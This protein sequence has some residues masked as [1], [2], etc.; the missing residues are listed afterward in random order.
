M[1]VLI[2]TSSFPR[3]TG[4]FAGNPVYELIKAL[5]KEEDIKIHVVAPTDTDSE[6]FER[7]NK[8]ICI[9]RFKYFIPQKWQKI[10]YGYGIPTNLKESILAKIQFPLFILSFFLTGLRTSINQCDVIHAHFILSGLIT[11]PIKK[12]IKKPVVLTVRGSGLRM[13]PKFFSKFAL[14]QAEAIISPHPELTE[15]IRDIGCDVIEIPN[16]VD[17]N[18][19]NPNI[20]TSYFKEEFGITTQYIISFIGRLYEFKDPITFVKS[21][22]HVL[23]RNNNVKF[24]IV[25]DGPL[26][27]KIKELIEKLNIEKY[28]ILTGTRDDVSVILKTSTIYT[29]LSPIENIWSNVIIESMKCGTPCIVTRSGLTEKYLIHKQSAYL[30]P[31]ENEVELA[32]AI[33]YLLEHKELREKLSKTAIGLMGKSG[34]SRD[35]VV[36]KTMEVYRNVIIKKQDKE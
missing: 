13:M 9:Y 19:F 2:L 30:V 34:F 10:A 12:I 6:T 14:K 36:K 3:Y 29:A 32:N 5:S 1:N 21:I 11:I 7:L 28:V 8:N 20:E 24:F 26:K 15:I 31:P 4:D 25:G 23:A 17:D 35:N 18:K 22:P 16:I 27:N 33:L